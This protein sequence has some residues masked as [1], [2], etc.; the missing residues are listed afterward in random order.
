MNGTSWNVM[1]GRNE[2]RGLLSKLSHPCGG[3]ASKTTQII[4]Y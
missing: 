4:S 3:L 2:T 1:V